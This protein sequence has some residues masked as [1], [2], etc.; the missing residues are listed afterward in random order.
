MVRDFRF[1]FLFCL[2]TILQFLNFG[3]ECMVLQLI[4]LELLFQFCYYIIN[5]GI[6]AVIVDLG[7]ISIEFLLDVIL[8][9]NSTCTY[10]AITC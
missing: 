7:D 10:S 8:V 5:E 6:S 4:V 3:N 1:L 9:H 2:D